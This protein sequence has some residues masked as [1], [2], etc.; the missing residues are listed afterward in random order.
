MEV[1]VA[2]DALELKIIET[3]VAQGWR[4]LRPAD[5][6]LWMAT[7]DPP[8][9]QLESGKWGP[10]MKR[11]P[12]GVMDRLLA[13]GAIEAAPEEPASDGPAGQRYRLSPAAL[14]A[15][16]MANRTPQPHLDP[17]RL[18]VIGARLG[19]D[20]DDGTAWGVIS[21]VTPEGARA[22][23]AALAE[24]ARA[25]AQDGGIARM[26]TLEMP[27]RMVPIASFQAMRMRNVTPT[28]WTGHASELFAGADPGH[29]LNIRHA[30]GAYGEPIRIL[31]ERPSSSDTWIEIGS[32]REEQLAE[33]LLDHDIGRDPAV[34][35]LL[36]EGF[37][38]GLFS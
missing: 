4:I 38:N 25:R 26:P 28:V 35:P 1:P 2:L 12:F 31:A 19:R 11:L 36:L 3:A 15:L 10:A 33:T 32:W 16:H 9:L 8:A 5:T 30:G 18:P 37:M 27:A 13:D 7:S 21:L 6:N 17:S 20:V 24:L 29:D 14:T 23:A 22:V 34:G